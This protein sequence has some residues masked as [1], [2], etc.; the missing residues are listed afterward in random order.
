MC[1]E[2]SI[3]FVLFY[4]ITQNNIFMCTNK[5]KCFQWRRSLIIDML[6]MHSDSL[7]Y[8]SGPLCWRIMNHFEKI[9][10]I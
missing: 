2:Q 10:K 6:Q 1:V 8:R 9:I 3:C 7:N 5:E 4:C